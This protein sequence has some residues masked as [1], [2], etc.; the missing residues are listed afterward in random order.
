VRRIRL[1][2]CGWCRSPPRG[3][4]TSGGCGARAP[5]PQRTNESDGSLGARIEA[6]APRRFARSGRFCSTLLVTHLTSGHPGRRSSAG[7]S[8]RLVS[9]RSGVRIS[10]SAFLLPVFRVHIPTGAREP[11]AVAKMVEGSRA[12]TCDDREVSR[13][14][15]RAPQPR[16]PHP[17]SR[18]REAGLVAGPA[19]TRL[20]PFSYRSD[21][22]TDAESGADEAYAAQR[23]SEKPVDTWDFQW[24]RGCR[25]LG[26]IPYK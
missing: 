20:R 11:P 6:G 18:T 4:R 26:R 12:A 3:Q 24:G 7:Q 2:Y 16:L 10:P 22:A 23:A 15:R 21:T 25:K 14:V 8:R 19:P 9:V 13:R 1:R 5:C 17:R